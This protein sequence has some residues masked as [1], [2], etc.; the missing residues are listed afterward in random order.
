MEILGARYATVTVIQTGGG[1][2]NTSSHLCSVSADGVFDLLVL[3][4]PLVQKCSSPKS[5]QEQQPQSVLRL[6]ADP[7]VAAIIAVSAG[8]RA[9]ARGRSIS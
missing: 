7:T 8:D 4:R 2:I 9:V 5:K 6:R 1:V 3:H